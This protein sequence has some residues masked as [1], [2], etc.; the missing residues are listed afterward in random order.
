MVSSSGLGILNVLVPPPMRAV[1]PAATWYAATEVEHG[2][3]V[4]IEVI[5][6]KTRA[7]QYHAQMATWASP[8][9]RDAI[10]ELFATYNVTLDPRSRELVCTY[11]RRTNKID[12]RLEAVFSDHTMVMRMRSMKIPAVR[13]E[14][15][16]V[17]VSATGDHIVAC[18]P[19]RLVWTDRAIGAHCPTDAVAHAL[20]V[21]LVPGGVVAIT[22]RPSL[23]YVEEPTA[24]P[25]N[26]TETLI[27]YNDIA[28]SEFRPTMRPTAD[29]T[30]DDTEPPGGAPPGTMIARTS[31]GHIVC[32][33]FDN[34][35]S[36]FSVG[37]FDPTPTVA[38]TIAHV[39]LDDTDDEDIEESAAAAAAA[40]AT[41]T[42]NGEPVTVVPGPPSADVAA[43][44]ENDDDD[45]D[46]D[47]AP[48][49]RTM[50]AATFY[51]GTPPE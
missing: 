25:I 44:M 30:P 10:A 7:N 15:E 14:Y 40:A 33:T 51:V 18:S 34:Y 17:S 26:L 37:E 47:D 39:H 31:T 48:V 1:V 16:C 22:A 23:V 27:R 28:E 11:D 49:G 12:D 24:T 38:E 20:D 4:D 41:W 36:V 19:D 21:V 45:D 43:A 32:H 9:Y 3:D 29:F 8:A 13:P 5:E 50:S 2:T 42:V 35:V 46:D 6:V